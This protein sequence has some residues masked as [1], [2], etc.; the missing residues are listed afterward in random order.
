MWSPIPH[1]NVTLVLADNRPCSVRG[2]ICTYGERRLS[3]RLE[4]TV[5]G[6]LPR[7]PDRPT[8]RGLSRD[9]VSLEWNDAARAESYEVQLL[10]DDQWT[11][12]PANGTEIVFD[13]ARAI[14]RGLPTADAYYFRVRALNSNG[15]SEWSDQLF[16][17]IRLDWDSE[18]TAGRNADIFPV[19]S[20]YARFGNLGG[21]LSPDEFVLN[22]TT[23]KVQFLVHSRESLWLGTSP[24][25]PADFTLFVGGSDYRGGE[26]MVSETTIADAGYWWPSASPECSADGPIRVVLIVYS[27]VPLGD[28]QKAPVTGYFRNFPSEHDGHE[29]FSFRIY[30]SEGI[31]TTADAL[32]DY[33]LSVSGGAVSGVEEASQPF[34]IRTAEAPPV[35]NSPATGLPTISGAAQVDETLTVDTSGIADSDGLAGATFSYQWTADDED[36][37]DATDSTYTLESDDLG[38]AIS[39][40]VSFTDDAGNAETLTSQA[41]ETVTLLIWSGTLTAG[42]SGTMSGYSLP[43]GTGT[44]SPSAFSIGVA[45]F[46]VRMVLEGDDGALTLGLDRQMSA[47]FTLHVGTALF[48][49]EDA[50]SS[51]SEDGTGYTYRW[52]QAGLDWS[53]EQSL[54]LRMTTAERPLT[55]AFEAT[56]ESHDGSADFTF[57]L[58]FSEEFSL[59]YRT[60]RDHAFTVTGGT[61]TRVRRLAPPGNIHWEITVRPD[62]NSAVTIVLPV[63]EDCVAQGAVCTEDDRV[64]ANRTEL[65]VPGVQTTVGE[66]TPQPGNNP[67]TGPPSISGAARVGTTLRVSLSDL[68]DAD[69]LS[70][71]SH[72]SKT[73]LSTMNVGGDRGTRI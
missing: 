51:P 7:V 52:D 36:I 62:S 9:S 12:L 43:Q 65:R 30:F 38:K 33:A 31:P 72:I 56:P 58:R 64:L 3:T 15:A 68:D 60:L 1:S 11:D 19:E 47:P 63:T 5:E 10:Q 22:G 13:G 71:P 27:G 29:D 4:H 28:R 57:K 25:L 24:E 23:Y 44:L 21:T 45:D 8:W 50:G 53:A 26:S 66:P 67:A 46:I 16:V 14:V 35:E 32:R 59:S 20:G 73:V 54:A 39:V 37:Q 41:T 42:S 48:A 34:E 70:P 18:L 69:G 6:P 49:R 40:R 55:A 61:V 17:P 2:A